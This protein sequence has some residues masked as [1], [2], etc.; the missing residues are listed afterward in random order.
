[1]SIVHRLHQQ[2][3]AFSMDMHVRLRVQPIVVGHKGPQ[4]TMRRR[5]HFEPTTAVLV[6]EKRTHYFAVGTEEV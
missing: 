2:F 4:L 3:R 5:R 6:R 1:V